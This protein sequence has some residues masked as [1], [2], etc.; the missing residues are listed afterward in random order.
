MGLSGAIA[1]N[2]CSTTNAS[3]WHTAI[4]VGWYYV[5]RLTG[6]IGL[7]IFGVV[8]LDSAAAGWLD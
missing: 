2:R 4:P 5:E 8:H 6:P 3:K 1:W 7:L